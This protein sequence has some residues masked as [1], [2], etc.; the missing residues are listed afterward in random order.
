MGDLQKQV[1][2]LAKE[3]EMLT[4]DNQRAQESL[5]LSTSEMG[6]LR[7]RNQELENKIQAL[8]E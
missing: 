4:Q 6:K 1:I 2:A 5:R 7:N 3:N 8:T